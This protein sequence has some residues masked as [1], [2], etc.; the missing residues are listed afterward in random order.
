[1]PVAEEAPARSPGSG[2]PAPPAEQL[3]AGP[4]KP[5]VKCWFVPP[6]VLGCRRPSAD[7]ACTGGPRTPGNRRTSQPGGVAAAGARRPACP[8]L[9][10]VTGAHPWWRLTHGPRLLACHNEWLCQVC[11]LPLPDRA[12]VLVDHLDS[13]DSDAALHEHCLRTSRRQLPAP[14][15]RIAGTMRCPRATQ[16][17]Q[18]RRSTPRSRRLLDAATL[19]DGPLL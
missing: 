19:D 2:S 3:C 7:L 15:H 12:W 8:W 17:P 5:T 18:Q 6:A 10:P 9:T 1:M 11:G 16:R 14:H 4:T 13:V